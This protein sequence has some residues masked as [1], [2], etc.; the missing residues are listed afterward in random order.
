MNASLNPVVSEGSVG[1]KIS[2][3]RNV[4]PPHVAILYGPN[5]GMRRVESGVS[6]D[7][8]SLLL[9]RYTSFY[10]IDTSYRTI[11]KSE[12]IK[13]RDLEDLN[14]EIL[15]QAKVENPEEF[16]ARFGP[17]ASILDPF[18]ENIRSYLKSYAKEFL[19]SDASSLEA[20]LD[21]KCKEI[22]DNG[23]VHDCIF[24]DHLSISLTEGGR[25]N[26]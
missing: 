20:D 18:Y 4:C 10:I 17:E 5:L 6:I 25:C 24:I 23:A 21:D 11:T 3:I 15:I 9:R 1:G 16:I 14:A 26:Y 12:V 22:R 2:E 13:T 7:R 8:L 19:A